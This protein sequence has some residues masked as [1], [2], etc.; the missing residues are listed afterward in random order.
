MNHPSNEN[1]SRGRGKPLPYAE[2][3]SSGSLW[4]GPCTFHS[5]YLIPHFELS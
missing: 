3:G 5:E 4:P 1:G 2:N